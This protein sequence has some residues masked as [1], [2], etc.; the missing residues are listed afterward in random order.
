[1]TR[2]NKLKQILRC[3]VAKNGV[4]IYRGRH[5]LCRK[6]YTVMVWGIS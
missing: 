2:H 6:K 4:A 3:G 5:S 1:M